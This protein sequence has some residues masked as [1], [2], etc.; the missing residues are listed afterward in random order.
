M[1]APLVNIE[2]ISISASLATNALA[3]LSADLAANGALPRTELE[4][5][6]ALESHGITDAIAA[7]YGTGDVFGLARKLLKAQ[8]STG[9]T[10]DLEPAEQ[11]LPRIIPTLLRGPLMFCMIATAMVGLHVYEATLR[12]NGAPLWTTAVGLTSGIVIAGGFMPALGW[13]ISSALSQR[14]TDMIPTLIARGVSFSLAVAGLVA[15]LLVGVSALYQVPLAGLV[16][17]GVSAL[18]LTLWLLISGSL[19]VLDHLLMASAAPSLTFGL[20]WLADRFWLGIYGPIPMLVLGYGALI[21]LLGGWLIVVLHRLSGHERQRFRVALPPAGQIF[22]GAIPYARYGALAVV[23]VLVG[24]LS[25]WFG[26]LTPGWTREPAVA[27]MNIVHLLGFATVILSQGATEYALRSFWQAMMR[28]ER[29]IAASDLTTIRAMIWQFVRRRLWLLLGIQV[30]AA[31]ACALVIPWL[32]QQYDLTPTLGPLN[33]QLLFTSLLAY[34]YLAWGF[35]DCSL[36]VALAQ[37]REAARLL[38]IATGVQIAGMMILNWFAGFQA[39]VFGS[40]I[41]AVILVLLAQ[42][43]LRRLLNRPDYVLYRAF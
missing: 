12:S 38:L 33:V 32:W 19:I 40:V 23:Y 5:A 17:L 15:A 31:L 41:S 11:P 14:T 3:G 1:S 4:L 35:F 16:G 42:R 8:P 18:G 2:S 6:A 20:A 29:Q 24:P 30:A 27:A 34:T 10:A 22:Y 9:E 36:L 28:S 37:P 26:Y 21:M 25:G 43:V 39:A 7:Q 13:R